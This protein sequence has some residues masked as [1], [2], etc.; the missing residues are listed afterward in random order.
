MKNYRTIIED[1]I[2]NNLTVL[3]AAQK[4]GCSESSIRK[5]ISEIKKSKN[6]SDKE[7]YIEYLEAA[8]ETQ[9]KGRKKGGQIGKRTTEISQET[10]NQ[11][12]EYITQDDYTLRELEKKFG[13]PSS[14]IYD[15]LIKNLSRKQMVE[16]EAIFNKHR[17]NSAK[18][19]KS[20]TENGSKFHKVG[21]EISKLTVRIKK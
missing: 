2:K 12:Y 15:A 11:L 5:Y 4:H 20:D 21:T 16:I 6:I 10:I 3:E 9:K 7:L 13:I 17:R 8:R 14:T 19:Y 18:N 1:I